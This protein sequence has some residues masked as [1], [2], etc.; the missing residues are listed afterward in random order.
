MRYRIEFL[1]EATEESSVCYARE[2]RCADLKLLRF[3]AAAWSGAV[4]RKYGAGG[5]Q[6]RDLDADGRIVALEVIDVPPS[7][8]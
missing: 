5:F 3:Q 6:I 4:K 1:T 8:H 7:I 2:P